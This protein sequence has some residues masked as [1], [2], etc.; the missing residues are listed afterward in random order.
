VYCEESGLAWESGIFM[1]LVWNSACYYKVHI[2]A[3]IGTQP[4]TPNHFG[5]EPLVRE[6]PKLTQHSSVFMEPLSQLIHPRSEV[7]CTLLCSQEP[8][9]FSAP[10]PM[11]NP[12]ATPM[13]FMHF[14]NPCL[15]TEDALLALITHTL[16]LVEEEY[17]HTLCLMPQMAY[18]AP[19]VPE[20]LLPATPQLRP[21]YIP[22]W[23]PVQLGPLP[24]MPPVQHL[25]LAPIPVPP[26]PVSPP[27][28]FY[29]V[30][31]VTPPVAPP[32]FFSQGYPPGGGA[33]MPPYFQAPTQPYLNGYPPVHWTQDL[34]YYAAPQ[35]GFEKF[36]DCQARQVHWSG[37][38]KATPFHHQLHHAFDSWPPKFAT[39]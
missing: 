11:A 3:Q 24:P 32:Q 28:A 9:S 16:N 6:L 35:G 10:Y 15:I 26:T 14:P 25:P 7:P 2:V 33:P 4:F 13:T 38:L 30:P 36:R 34:L 17:L 31:L 21:M 19:Q 39:N 27:T 22:P 29:Q 8:T 23:P 5:S 1:R 37:P 18:N 12:P 20:P